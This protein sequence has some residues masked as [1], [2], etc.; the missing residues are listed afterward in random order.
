MEVGC[1][2]Y[3]LR[4]FARAEAF[5]RMQLLGLTTVELWT[6]HASYLDTSVRARDVASDAAAYGLTLRA[7][8][9]GGLFA[10]PLTTVTDRLARAVEFATAL[11]VRLVTVILDRA[12]V[13]AADAIAERAGVQ[14]GLENHWYTELSRPQSVQAAIADASPAI[15]AAIDTGHFAFLGYDLGE[16]GCMLGSRTLHVHLKVVRPVGWLERVFR[17]RRRQLR[18]PP[19]RPGDGDGLDGFVDALGHAGYRGFLAIEDERDGSVDASLPRYCD[20]AHALTA[21]WQP[22]VAEQAHG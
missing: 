18:M 2:S 4:A 11:G 6:G 9:V 14:I 19:G 13:P 17:R 15:G 1:N 12:A 16:V 20:R 21:R 8:C 5:R 10:L 22:A 3:S 7:Y